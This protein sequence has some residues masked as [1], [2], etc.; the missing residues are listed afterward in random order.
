[1]QALRLAAPALALAAVLS[2]VFLALGF[3]SAAR[4]VGEAP[5]PSPNDHE[6][7]ARTSQD[8]VPRDARRGKALPVSMPAEDVDGEPIPGLP[9]YPGSVRAAYS[10]EQAG[11]LSFVRAR[12]LTERPPGAVRDFYDGVFRSG[13]WRVANVDYAG[14]EWIFVALH[15]GREAGVGVS[16]RG[17]VS[18][19]NVE[20]SR[21]LAQEDEASAGGSKR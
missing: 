6:P 4:T 10:E 1:L 14:G 20:V 19:V 7:L 18:V 15:G 2:S 9:R 17:E 5:R 13:G 11:D 21:P 3:V 12:F 8:F 16:S